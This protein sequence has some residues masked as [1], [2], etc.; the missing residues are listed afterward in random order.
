MINANSFRDLKERGFIYQVTDETAVEKL[1]GSEK[2]HFYAGFDPTGNSLHVGH[3]LPVMVMRRLQQC[4]H[5]PIVLV[6][7]ATALVGDPSGKQEARPILSKETAAENAAALKAQLSRFI[8]IEEGRAVFVNNADWFIDLK[9]IDFL[10]DVGTH[11]SVNRMLSMDSVKMRMET[12]ISFLEFN[13]M[14]LQ[15][16]DFHV[17][18]QKYGCKLQAGG[19]D[20]W[21]NIVSGVELV[22]KMDQSEV[23]GMTFPLLLNS[24]GQKFGKTVAGSVWLDKTR[25]S[26]FDYYQFWRNTEDSEVE[27]LLFF[28]TTLPTDEIRS[29][30]ALKAPEINRAKEILAFEATLLAHGAEEASK[31]Y[32]AA[33]SKFGFADPDGKIKTSSSIASVKA[34]ASA[35]LA[36]LPTWK[37]AASEIPEEGLWIVKFLADCGLAS[38][39]GEARRLLQGGGAYLNDSRLSDLDLKVKKSDFIDGSL[40]LKAG[41]KNIRRVVLS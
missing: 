28:F 2:V 40:I 39:N 19:Q 20:Q 10:R 1:L 33:G 7:G 32:I 24:N 5:V 23:F 38:S 37:I 4:G 18:F 34:D 41:K 21:G 30:A 8:S 15:S 13:Y 25:T 12:G 17:L 14:L 3:L 31:A 16:Y 35:G 6:G 11:F 9:Y 36:D 26:V 27:K 22:R 29:L